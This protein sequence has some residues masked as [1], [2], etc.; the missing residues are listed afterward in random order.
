MVRVD[1]DGVG[2]FALFISSGAV[3]L[4]VVLLRAY[5]ARLSA[6]IEMARLERSEEVSSDVSGDIQL[7]EDQVRR[8]TERLDFT[9]KLLGAGDAKR[10]D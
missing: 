5:Q 10:R 2:T 8:L 4:G 3:G 6:K 7:L 9:E 1:W